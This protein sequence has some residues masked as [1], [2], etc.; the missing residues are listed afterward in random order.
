MPEHVDFI[1]YF[2]SNIYQ[3]QFYRALCEEAGQY[4][5]GEP[6]RP[7]HKCSLYGRIHRHDILFH[8]QLALVSISNTNV[9]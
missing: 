1:R 5:K 2:T 4:V 7:L 3:F 9:L 6:S 8:L